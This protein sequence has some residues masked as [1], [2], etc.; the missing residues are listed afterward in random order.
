MIAKSRSY[1]WSILY[2]VGLLSIYLG[3]RIIGGGKARWVVTIAGALFVFA[4]AIVRALR[5]A[6][7]SR[8]RRRV[9]GYLLLLELVGIA[10]LVVYFAQSDLWTSFGAKSLQETSPRLSVI[11]AA[12]WP[13]LMVAAL[14]PLL[15]VEMS[16]SAMAHAPEVEAG[17]VRDATLSGLGV[18]ASL[19]FAF[20]AVFVASERDAKWDLSYFRTAKPGPA[21]RKIAQALTEPVLVSIFF[22]PANEVRDEVAEYFQDLGGEAKE[23]EVHYY[24]QAVDP[25]KAR[26]LG[27][28]G[29]GAVVLSRGN[30]REQLLLGL[31]LERARTQLRS[32]DQEVQKRLLAVAK[33][34]R[35]VYLTVGHG[36]R[37]NERS[38]PTDQRSTLGS[39]RE[40]LASQNHELRNLGPAEGLATEVPGDAA[41]LMVI[42]P[43]SGFLPEES[44]A[45]RRYFDR[46]GRVWISLEQDARLDFK[47]LVSGLGLSFVP[48][49]LANDQ[50][51]YRRANQVSDRVIII[52]AAY[53]S[54]PSVTS[55]SQ[56]GARAPLVLI[57]SGYL[58]EAK[59][60][61]EGVSVDF[62]VS[63]L[64]TTWNDLNRNFLFDPPG[65]VRKAWQ[66]AAA[67][68]RKKP[69][70]QKPEEDGRAIVL[71]NA[72]ALTDAVFENS[73][74]T[75]LALDGIRWLL[76]EEAIAGPAVSETD[77]PV[78]HTRKQDVFWFYSTIFLVPAA[79]LGAGFWV[80]SRRRRRAERP[81]ARAEVPR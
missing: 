37:S 76:G 16:Y 25:A 41:A 31:E 43:T 5:V 54:H 69:G 70:G 51:Y 10:S 58:E 21:T 66:L 15:L 81:A 49:P 38:S 63:A 62:T 32:L 59:E 36:E 61:P 33:A 60:K 47:D 56:L 71:A 26:E 27:V 73:G 20:C 44:A 78:E 77:V 17:R 19:I 65:E 35:V 23:L 75:Y 79:V 57:G 55:L 40:L 72:A 68:T 22:P 9:E 50:F 1:L 2:A 6:A 53:S 45:L 34:R 7:S 64:P 3:E 80:T 4:A 39:L 29:N 18:A 8:E 24:D 28:S 14:V 30:R 67:V 46:G 11:L 42:G 52:T 48:V 74:N 12:A 13:A